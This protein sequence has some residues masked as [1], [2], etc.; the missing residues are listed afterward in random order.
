MNLG[1]TKPLYLLPFD[2]RHSYESGMFHVKPPLSQQ[3]DKAGA[4]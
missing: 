3:H 1:Y 2:H 4:G